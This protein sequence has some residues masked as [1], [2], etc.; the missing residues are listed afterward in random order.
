[1]KVLDNAG[2]IIRVRGHQ[3]NNHARVTA[4]RGPAGGELAL[5]VSM[6]TNSLHRDIRRVFLCHSERVRYRVRDTDTRCEM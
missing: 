5:L 3:I 6:D 2:L 4:W 1:M